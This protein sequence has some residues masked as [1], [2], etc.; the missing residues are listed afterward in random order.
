MPR[1]KK[2]DHVQTY[3]PDGNK[4]THDETWEG[5]RPKVTQFTSEVIPVVVKNVKHTNN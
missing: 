1:A 5:V 3:A 4:K 2:R